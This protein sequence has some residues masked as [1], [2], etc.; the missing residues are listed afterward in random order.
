[1]LQQPAEQ[2][3]TVEVHSASPLCARAEAAAIAVTRHAAGHAGSHAADEVALAVA[4]RCR[5][6]HVRS[7]ARRAARLDARRRGRPVRRRRAWHLHAHARRD[8]ELAG[9][10]PRLHAALLPLRALP[11]HQR[12]AGARPVHVAPPLRAAAA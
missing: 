6:A 7:S 11:T 12:R 1:M 10:G 4:A 8:A 5:A 3:Y 9:S 2:H